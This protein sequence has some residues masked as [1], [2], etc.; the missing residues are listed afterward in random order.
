[1]P[2]DSKIVA[3]EPYLI[4]S[5]LP[6]I[7]HSPSKTSLITN[8]AALAHCEEDVLPSPDY[9]S[10]AGA[11]PADDEQAE[12]LRNWDSDP[13]VPVP[14]A[15][16]CGPDRRIQLVGRTLRCIVPAAGLLRTGRTGCARRRVAGL[17][18]G[19]GSF[20]AVGAAAGSVEGFG[21]GGLGC[22]LRVGLA[23]SWVGL[24]GD[25]RAGLA[26][27]MRLGVRCLCRCRL[28]VRSCN[29]S[30]SWGACCAWGFVSYLRRVMYR[31]GE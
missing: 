30:R 7:S 6:P 10:P 28:R 22:L 25:N 21:R 11:L 26:V 8:P 19:L 4:P 13:T 23:G 1:V 2:L 17:D 27:G 14:P 31:K 18:P 20:G 3:Q 15:V 9:S 29:R 24:V 5:S 12:D 16:R